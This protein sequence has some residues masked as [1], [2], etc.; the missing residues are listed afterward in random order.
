MA[1]MIDIWAVTEIMQNG[2]PENYLSDRGDLEV[3]SGTTITCQPLL[4]SVDPR[5]PDSR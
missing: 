5:A 3:P 4:C 2:K 1:A